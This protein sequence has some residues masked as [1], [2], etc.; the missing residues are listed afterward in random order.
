MCA[1][2]TISSIIF[3][4]WILQFVHTACVKAQNHYLLFLGI[5]KFFLFSNFH[6]HLPISKSCKQFLVYTKPYL[7]LHLREGLLHGLAALTGALALGL[8]R[9][10]LFWIFL[11]RYET[12]LGLWPSLGLR[13]CCPN[14]SFLSSHLCS[15]TW[16]NFNCGDILGPLTL[17]LELFSRPSFLGNSRILLD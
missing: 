8:A 2:Y 1:V 4:I 15:R 10:R 13:A 9:T 3:S 7:G 6:S 17:A 16:G 14:S 5:K 11:V 12:C